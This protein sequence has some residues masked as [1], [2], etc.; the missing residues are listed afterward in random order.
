M[1]TIAN[2]Y[3]GNSINE[4]EKQ[5]KYV[6]LSDG[7]NYI[8]TKDVSFEHAINYENSVKIPYSES[9]FRI[10]YKNT[11]LLCIEGGSAGRKIAILEQDVCFGNK[12]CAFQSLGVNPKYL[13]YYLQNPLFIQVFKSKTTG[14]IGGVSVNT[15]KTLIFALPPL[16]EQKRIVKEIERF[17]PLLAEYDKLEQQA[18]KLDTE[19]YDK[20]K[21]SILQYA[22]QGKLVKQDENDE[23]A[24]VL[25][26]R[27]RAEKKVQLGKKYVESYIYKGDDNCY[28]EHINGKSVDITDELPFDLP[29]G[30]VWSR[31]DDLAL[32]KKGPFGSSLTKDMFVPKSETSVKVYEQKNAIYK[33]CSLGSYY[34]TANKYKIMK[35]FEVFPEDII[36]SCAGTI[37]ET[38]VLPSDAPKGI[39]NQAL[40]KIKLFNQNIV[41][42]YL[43]YFDYILKGQAQKSSKGSAIKNIPPFDILKKMLMPIPPLAEQKR[44]V[45]KIDEIFAQL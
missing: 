43:I 19:I 10:A 18:T 33:S 38:Y 35:S 37:G 44:I 45:K 2:I 6:G 21:K 12:L 13:Y 28:Y 39:I 17:E 27:I 15:L 31:L 34:I 3:T 9:N 42:F 30:W 1:S 20:L 25:L 24:N 5:R 16:A 26:E 22:I 11:P 23:P 32:Y 41:D 29:N 14:I 7:Y 8:A 4:T 40:M 36:V